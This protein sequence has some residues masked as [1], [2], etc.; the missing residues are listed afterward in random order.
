M[1]V[2]KTESRIPAGLAATDLGEAVVAADGRCALVSFI[3]SPLAVS[4]ENTYVVFVTDTTLAAATQ[5]FEWTFTPSDG[6][7]PNVQ[8]T[9]EGET[10]FTPASEGTVD[11]V[12]RLLDSSST[13]QARLELVQDVSQPNPTIEAMIANTADGPGPGMGNTDVLTELVND[14]T[15]Y[16]LDVKLATPEAGDAFTQFLFSTITGG[17]LERTSDK[18]SY[19]LDQVADS[20]NTG[21]TDYISATSPGIGVAGIRLV[22]VAMML[23]PMAIPYTE[24]PQASDANA[25]GDEALRKQLAAMNESDRIDLFNL[26]RF[27]KS[28]ITLCGK[29]LQALRD[30]LFPGVTFDDIMTKMSGTM[31]VWVTRSY[32]N[33]PLIRT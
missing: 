13:E 24:L 14:H 4:R 6:T 10:T 29:L 25:A 2:R 11:L 20:L 12:V 31:G 5:S 3:T 8:T 32:K 26:V 21:N 16:Y 27:P 22:L 15:P 19:L 23:P 18:R 7:A 1:P 9:D 30:K 28:N 33:G 17:I